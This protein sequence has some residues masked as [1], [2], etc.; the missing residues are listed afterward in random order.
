MC[1]IVQVEMLL[2]GFLKVVKWICECWPGMCGIVQVENV[3]YP[4]RGRESNRKYL[5]S[6]EKLK[7]LKRD[8]RR[9]R[10]GLQ[11]QQIYKREVRTKAEH[12]LK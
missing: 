3:D 9:E 8:F 2:H 5:N 6:M 11:Q 4:A 12:F 10:P 1:R 7:L